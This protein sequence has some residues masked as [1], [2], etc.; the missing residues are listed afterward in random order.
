LLAS[1]TGFRAH[2]GAARWL[3]G[4]RQSGNLPR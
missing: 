4:I 1:W 3:D 2:S